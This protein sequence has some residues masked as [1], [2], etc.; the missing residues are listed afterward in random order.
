MAARKQKPEK[1]N[2]IGHLTFPYD[3]KIVKLVFK[4][5]RPRYVKQLVYEGKVYSGT[6]FDK[7]TLD[8]FES[9]GYKVVDQAVQTSR[10]ESLKRYHEI[11]ITAMV[12]YEYAN[13][14]GTPQEI[15]ISYYAP[16]LSEVTERGKK[17]MT[18]I[19]EETGIMGEGDVYGKMEMC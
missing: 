14:R 2:Y 5:A 9:V 15:V 19:Y 6:N 8:F 7:N 18:S 13:R 4:P 17:I 11:P 3:E 12:E 1:K 10:H 16:N